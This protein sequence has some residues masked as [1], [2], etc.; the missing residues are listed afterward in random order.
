M[1]VDPAILNW[2]HHSA[3]LFNFIQIYP[4][5]VIKPSFPHLSIGKLFRTGKKHL[6]MMA[7]IPSCILPQCLWYSKSILVDKASLYFLMFSKKSSNYDSQSF[8]DDGSSKK[9]HQLETGYNL[10]ESSY[11]KWLQLVDS[12]PERWKFVIKENYENATN[13]IIQDH[14]T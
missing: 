9:W 5:K 14:H 13:L 12:I 10:R 8:S 11:F 1:A 7:K 3:L 4:L 6:A 2:K